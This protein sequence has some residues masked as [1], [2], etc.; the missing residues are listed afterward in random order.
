M[1]GP[2][3]AHMQGPT[4]LHKSLRLHYPR[5]FT[6]IPG[7]LPFVAPASRLDV[8]KGARGNLLLLHLLLLRC[9]LLPQQ[10]DTLL[11]LH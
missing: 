2:P 1:H 6:Q 3:L 9:P 4:A 8:T 7:P 10:R 5:L 11:L